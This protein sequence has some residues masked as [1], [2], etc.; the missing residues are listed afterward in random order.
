MG[1]S[2]YGAV[3]FGGDEETQA[4]LVAAAL[5]STG[6]GRYTGFSTGSVLLS[7]ELNPR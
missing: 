3:G 4:E 7:L 6:R 1:E 2:S 5:L